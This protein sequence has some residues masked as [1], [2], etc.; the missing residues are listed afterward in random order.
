M[1]ETGKLILKNALWRYR[2]SSNND[3]DAATTYCS[4]NCDLYDL[5]INSWILGTIFLAL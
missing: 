1:I 5:D 2:K 4:L 3:I